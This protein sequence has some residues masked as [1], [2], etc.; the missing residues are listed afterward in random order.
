MQWQ[1]RS[2]N[3]SNLRYFAHFNWECIVCHVIK[4]CNLHTVWK[5]FSSFVSK[6]QRT[7]S[8]G[9]NSFQYKKA[10]LRRK[11][12]NNNEVLQ[13]YHTISVDYINFTVSLT[14]IYD[15]HIPIALQLVWMCEVLVCIIRM[16]S[17]WAEGYIFSTLILLQLLPSATL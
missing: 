12:R 8:K 3:Y 15:F 2:F 11:Q 4:L 16:Q 13:R 6:Q 7:V 1:P 5:Q 9:E 10:E 14:N 17:L